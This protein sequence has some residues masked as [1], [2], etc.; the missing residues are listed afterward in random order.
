[1]VQVP[2]VNMVAVVPETVQ[3]A[4]VVDAKLT[5]RPE[6]AVA[7][8]VKV[9]TV[10]AWL[11][12]CAKVIVCE[13]MLTVK[14]C[15]TLVAALTFPL[16]AWLAVIEQVPTPAIVTV[17]PETVQTGVVVEV[18]LTARLEEAVAVIP[19]GA[20]PK[21]TSLKGPKVIVCVP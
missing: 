5:A 12:G 19:N 3:T 8:S 2:T 13:A 1:M 9:G 17:E 11:G 20:A 15:T 4:A 21:V 14:V 10:S 16:P 7:T 18:K 6:E